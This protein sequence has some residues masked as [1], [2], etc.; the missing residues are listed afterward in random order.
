[1]GP[2][3][4][5]SKSP[6]AP[7]T[8][9]GGRHGLWRCLGADVSGPGSLNFG[10]ALHHDRNIERQTGFDR[11]PCR[12]RRIYSDYQRSESY[13]RA[14]LPRCGPA[15][16]KRTVC[17]LCSAR[18]N[19]CRQTPAAPRSLA[20]QQPKVSLD[21]FVA[22]QNGNAGRLYPDLAA[23]RLFQQETR[24]PAPASGVA[25]GLKTLALLRSCRL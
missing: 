12:A 10:A 16:P 4:S 6:K 18:I 21:G 7:G 23:L 19:P 9:R 22:D 17:Q 14:S 15:F 13:A 8:V 1:M 11:G 2:G 24:T 20:A 25:T 5:P 3:Q